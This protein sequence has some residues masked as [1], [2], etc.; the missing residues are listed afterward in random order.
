MVAD[1]IWKDFFTDYQTRRVLDSSEVFREYARAELERD[2][3]RKAREPIEALEKA[4]AIKDQEEAYLNEIYS[5][6]KKIAEN[7]VLKAKFKQA[8]AALEAHPELIQ[9]VDPNFIYGLDLL[10]LGE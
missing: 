6:N 1:E 10:D 9:K 7:P 4:A 8:K 3:A 5:L 2:A